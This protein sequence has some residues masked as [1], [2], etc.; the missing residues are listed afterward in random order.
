MAG[1]FRALQ[2][3]PYL[4]RTNQLLALCVNTQALVQ[5]SVLEQIG[6][7]ITTC[8]KNNDVTSYSRRVLA[9]Y[10][11]DG[12]PLSSNRIVYD[13]LVVLRNVGARVLAQEDPANN[14]S[15]S[16]SLKST[17]K[18]NK[19][20]W[21]NTIDR[22]WSTLMKNAFN[23]EQKDQK[24]A[25]SLRSVYVMSIGYYEDIRKFAE[26]SAQD[27]EKWAIDAYMQ[28]I[29]GTSLVNRDIDKKKKMKKERK[30][31]CLH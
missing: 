25:S 13:L 24:L 28:E 3:T 12:I 8:L 10:L 4:F 20:H 7:I 5:D 2:S 31:E 22:S 19:V 18:T 11:E 9:R 29:M 6:T 1:L 23:V 21:T 14:H 16:S 15:D 27:G 30:R 26:K 17:A